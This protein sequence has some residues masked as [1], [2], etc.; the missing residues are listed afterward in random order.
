MLSSIWYEY[1]STL[2]EDMKQQDRQITLVT[3]NCPSHPRP[4]QP[5]KGYDGPPPPNLTHVTLI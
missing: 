4:N 1:L 5:P 3:D 2:N